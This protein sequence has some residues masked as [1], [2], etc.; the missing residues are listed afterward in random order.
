M[1]IYTYNYK[2]VYHYYCYYYFTYVHSM[3]ICMLMK[4]GNN[5]Q[6][7]KCRVKYM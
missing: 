7:V 6:Y 4:K 5:I 1:L 3:Y 2:Y